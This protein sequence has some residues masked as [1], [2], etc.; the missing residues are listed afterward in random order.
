MLIR[1][2]RDK[3][4]RR[5]ETGGE[6]TPRGDDDDDAKNTLRGS[7]ESREKSLTPESES[8]GGE[9]G[10]Q[11]QSF[12]FRCTCIPRNAQTHRSSRTL[13]VERKCYHSEADLRTSET[14][15]GCTQRIDLH[16]RAP[17]PKYVGFSRDEETLPDLQTQ[18]M[19]N[20]LNSAARRY[21]QVYTPVEKSRQHSAIILGVPETLR[22][23]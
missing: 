21:H 8:R 13:L 10:G 2:G 16:D 12:T 14:T 9:T 20:V 7:C 11:H 1:R 18:A 5:R 17:Y 19:L 22:T 3:R 23:R 15:V 6:V 4:N